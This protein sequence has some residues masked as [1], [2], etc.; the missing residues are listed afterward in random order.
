MIKEKYHELL[1]IMEPFFAQEGYQKSRKRGFFQ[2]MVSGKIIKIRMLLR[3]VRRSGQLFE[4]QSPKRG[5]LQGAPETGRR[6]D[7][8]SDFGGFC[9]RRLSTDCGR[10]W[11]IHAGNQAL[12]GAGVHAL[13]G[14]D[15]V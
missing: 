12:S 1:Q 14:G 8:L 11:G 3:S 15:D 9:E 7:V 13:P 4:D 2:K 5:D 10:F 6:V